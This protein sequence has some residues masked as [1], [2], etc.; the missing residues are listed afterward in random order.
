MQ[1][2]SLALQTWVYVMAKTYGCGALHG[3]FLTT[4]LNNGDLAPN[5]AMSLQVVMGM[6]E[7]PLGHTNDGREWVG[8]TDMSEMRTLQGRVVPGH[9]EG[10]P[11]PEL[12]QLRLRAAIAGVLEARLFWPRISKL[13]AT[14]RLMWANHLKNGHVPYRRDCAT[15]LQAAGTGR[16]HKRVDR[17]QPFSLALDVAGPLKTKGRSMGL[18]DENKLKYMLVGAY[19]VPKDLLMEGEVP[20]E[21]P[22][23]DKLKENDPLEECEEYAPSEAEDLFIPEEEFEPDLPPPVPIPE[24]GDES[25]EPEDPLKK[26][27]EELTTKVE[28]VTLYLMV[29]MRSRHTHDVLE[30]TQAMYNKLRRA[31]LPV[32]QVHSDRA[33]EFRA[34]SF[35][36]WTIDKGLFH[37]RTSGSEPAAN[38][39]AECAVKFFKRRA[40]QL[41]ITSSAEARDW[42]LAAQ[43]A[44]EL[45]WRA[46]MP[47]EGRPR[48]PLPA[49]GQEVWYKIKSY[50]GSKGKKV[51]GPLPDLPP[52]WRKASYRGVA[53]DVPGGHVLC[54]QDGG[55]VIA[56]GIRMDIVEPE[57]LDL[58]PPVAAVVPAEEEIP[59][60]RRLLEDKG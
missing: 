49:F 31:S 22:G 42:P 9:A 1:P 44:A 21:E 40:R 18:I 43:H 36:R 24:P 19:R 51:V 47:P 15:C 30:A 5:L 33:R 8:F 41:L 20:E 11:P 45:H 59:P 38:G 32:M 25:M 23:L 56:K 52:R 28:L 58:L 48:E 37:S 16:A 12:H 39:T 2:R 14:D 6:H 34:R 60:E 54:R 7:V 55:L 10:Y 17:P 4:A 29:P 35:R 57:R 27:I 26:R 13:T 46:M 3:G 53:P 50:A